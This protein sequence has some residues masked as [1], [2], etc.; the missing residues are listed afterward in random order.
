MRFSTAAASWCFD[1]SNGLWHQRMAWDSATGTEKVWAPRVHGFLNG[2]HVVGDRSTGTLSK[3]DI[4]I[5]AD[6]GS[7]IRRVR[8]GPPL[9]AESRERLVV[10]EF[11]LILEPGLGLVSGQGSDPQVMFRVSLD[12]KT[13]GSER[14][15]SAGKLGDYRRRV[16]WLRCGS[17]DVLWMPE[18]SVTDPI[19][20]RLS[21]ANIEGSG[22]RQQSSRVQ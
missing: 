13:W 12:G 14:L 16:R 19:P 15:A 1:F 4:T 8:V 9:W 20:W 6:N 2:T 21:A 18:I 7:P 17:S 10:S 3:L 5:G 11:G 22:Y